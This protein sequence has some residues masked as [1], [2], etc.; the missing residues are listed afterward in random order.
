MTVE[1]RPETEQLVL[2][3]LERGQFHSVEEVITHAVRALHG[4]SEAGVEPAAKQP[5]GQF[6]LESPLRDSGFRIERKQDFPR[7]IEL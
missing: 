5:L 4:V 2:K 1:L 6:L 7:L 3:E